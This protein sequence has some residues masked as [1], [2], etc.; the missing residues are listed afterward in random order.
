[1]TLHRSHHLTHT[2][3]HTLTVHSQTMLP[4]QCHA[5]PPTVELYCRYSQMPPLCSEGQRSGKLSLPCG[6]E[7]CG[8]ICQS[9]HSTAGGREEEGEG[10]TTYSV[11]VLPTDLA[12]LVKRAS[13]YLISVEKRTSVEYSPVGG[14]LPIWIVEGES[15]HHI[16]MA[17]QCQ[18]FLT[19]L[20]S[21]HFAC[22]V[23]APS[24]KTEEKKERWTLSGKR[25]GVHDK[26]NGVHNTYDDP[27]L[28]MAILVSGRMCVLST[29]NSWNC[30]PWG[31]PSLPW[32][33]VE[34]EERGR[35]RAGTL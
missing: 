24:Y 6:P 27:D 9:L 22:P 29:L 12:G 5:P 31:S 2:H 33:S 16:L 4:A 11:E 13:S 30:L 35:W 23:I 19:T 20:P 25:N 26:R 28:L 14:P 7:K 18:Q 34:R 1:M 17:F 3:S 21:P 32:S 15:I 8:N 10:C